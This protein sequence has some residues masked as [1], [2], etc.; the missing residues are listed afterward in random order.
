MGAGGDGTTALTQAI[1]HPEVYGR[2][3]SQSAVLFGMTLGDMFPPVDEQQLTVYLAWGTYDMRSPHEAWDM[4]RNNREAWA[5]MRENGYRPAGGEVPEGHGWN[6][7]RSHTDE[8]LVALF[9][10]TR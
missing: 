5:A 6:C 4:A 10:I 2:V 3:G 8:M 9:P 1:S 7:W